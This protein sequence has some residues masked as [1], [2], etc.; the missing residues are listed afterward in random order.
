MQRHQ[1]RGTRGIHRHRRP[2]QPQ[3]I[4][5]PTR[6]DTQCRTGEPVSFQLAFDFAAITGVNHSDEYPGR[7]A[8]QRG[9]INPAALQSLP[10]DFQHQPLLRIHRQGLVGTNA[11]KAGVEV[12]G[13][14]QESAPPC[15]GLAARVRVRIEHCVDIPAP[16][17]GKL[18]DGI[19]ALSQHLPQRFRRIRSPGIPAAHAN[20]RHRLGELVFQ[21]RDPPAGAPQIRGQAFEVINMLGGFRQDCS[22]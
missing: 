2:L 17:G 4:R 6:G 15:V 20:Q 11:E 1:G 13:I 12:S 21:L 19:A 18:R 3:H 9:R 14:R 5:H 16:I 7:G 8:A 10:R 22:S